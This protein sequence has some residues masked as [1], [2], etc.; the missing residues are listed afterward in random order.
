ML[1]VDDET[2]IRSLCRHLLTAEKMQCDE[3]A[4]GAAA[5]KAVTEKHYDLVLLDVNM[6]G[7]SGSEALKHLRLRGLCDHMKI[8]VFSGQASSDEMS[9]MLLNGADDYLAKPFSVA[10]F[11]GRVRAALRLKAAQDRSVMLNQQLLNLNAELENDMKGRESDYQQT[12][13]SLVMGLAQLVDQRDAR[14]RNHTKRLQRFCRCLGEAAMK[15][16][17]FL[18]RVDAVFLELL[19]AVIPLHDVGK[20]ALPDHILLKG[21]TFSVEERILMQTHT[22]AAA[23]VLQ[24]VVKEY[25][26]AATFL[27]MAVDVI[28]HHHERFDGTGYPDHLAGDAIPLAARFVA[29]VDVYDALRSRR[30]WKPAL[31]H[32]TA[33][34][35]MTQAS[36]GQFDPQL[37]AI[38]QDNHARFEVIFK[39]ESR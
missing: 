18:G 38:F 6:P 34:Q 24:S 37:I 13:N 22:T 39:D 21:G 8:I 25:P 27:K 1:I 14:D 29:I 35:I 17:A 3:V 30:V 20:I 23:D 15:S 31:A 12:R 36:I 19:E 16:P 7:M 32:T 11:L 9:H 2:E 33:V 10:Q 5:I 26:G 28:R 4:D